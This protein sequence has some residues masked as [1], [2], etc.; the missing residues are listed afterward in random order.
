MLFV[1]ESESSCHPLTDPSKII[2][3]V[4]RQLDLA[5]NKAKVPTRELPVIF[6]PDG[7]AAPGY[8]AD[9]RL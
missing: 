3:T 9:G 6:T 7:V 1:G 2:E 5:K 4:L 8:A